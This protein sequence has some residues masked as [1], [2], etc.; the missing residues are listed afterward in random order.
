MPKLT[1]RVLT[2]FQQNRKEN[3]PEEKWTSFGQIIDTFFE[4]GQ[5]TDTITDELNMM[6]NYGPKIIRTSVGNAIRKLIAD[7]EITYRIQSRGHNPRL[8]KEGSGRRPDFKT[9]KDQPKD[10]I[11]RR[12]SVRVEY[13]CKHC[14]EAHIAQATLLIKVKGK[15]SIGIAQHKCP[16]CF[17]I[18]TCE[19]R[20]FSPPKRHMTSTIV[21]ENTINPK[22]PM[23]VVK[24][25]FPYHQKKHQQPQHQ[26]NELIPV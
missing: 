23:E 16:N 11:L 15:E 12:Y 2:W 22:Y 8:R 10:G 9:E 13:S 21:R 5:S 6:T 26:D 18:G 4:T 24:P 14:K 25:I 3:F 20:Y 19:G 7:N 1:E 17:S